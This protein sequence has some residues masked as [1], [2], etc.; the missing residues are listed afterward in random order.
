M[1]RPI[2]LLLLSTAVAGLAQAG[3]TLP[4]RGLHVSAPKP[5]DMP[6]MMRLIEALPKEGVNTLVIEFDYQYQFTRRPEV[7]GPGALS[8][9]N[10][11]AIAEAC[12]KAGIK[13]IPQINLLGHQS[14]GKV[15]GAL[16]QAHPE[17]DETEGL[18]PDNQGIYCRSYCPLHPKVHEVVFD[19]I[20]ELM[21]ATGADTFH[22]GMDEVFF[23]GEDGCPRCKGKDKAELFAG[24]V[25]TIHDHLAASGRKMW[26]WGDRLLDG[27]STGF[28]KWEASQ[29]GTQAAIRMIPKDIV[30]C[31][32]HYDRA[33]PTAAYF[34]IEGFP[35][36]TSPWRKADVAM[37]E[38]DQIETVRG[39]A[40]PEVGERLQGIL[41]T[42]W[43]P[44]V[45][46]AKAY[47]GEPLA[48]STIN[49]VES[50]ASFKALFRQIRLRHLN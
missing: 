6:L 12:R 2:A 48:E 29:N 10:V 33:L 16:L 46:F 21:E 11:Q 15:N 35:V 4:I 22:A 49:G 5:E 18:Y 42:S 44:F 43:T 27:Q 36:V 9:E 32:W 1:L 30:L 7:A 41:A 38:L 25:K 31:D 34:A 50:A 20:D 26:M 37:S 17:F 13:L 45:A 40:T 3:D 28:G 24:E 39:Q 19:L 8:R 47:F 14:W 23:L